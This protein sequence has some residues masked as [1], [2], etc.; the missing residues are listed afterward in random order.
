MKKLLLLISLFFSIHCL[1][2]AQ[3]SRVGNSSC[4]WEAWFDNYCGKTYTAGKNLTIQVKAKNYH[5]IK[6]MELY[7]NG[8]YVGKET[9]YPYDWGKQGK[10]KHLKNM[11]AGTYKMEVKIVDHCGKTKYLKYCE[12]YV[13]GHEPT[14]GCNY[15]NLHWIADI[16]HKYPNHYICEYKYNGHQYFKVYP[17]GQSHYTEYWY[18]CSGHQ[19]CKF[20][21]G[22]PCNTV[23]YAKKV[24][25]WYEPEPPHDTGGGHSCDYHDL[26][27]IQDIKHKYP[28]H[29]ICE[30]RYNGKT[31]Y[32][33]Y[34]CNKSHYTEYWY[35][36]SGH[37]VCKFQNGHACNTVRYAKKVKCWYEPQPPTNNCNYH[38]LDWIE[39][40]KRKY[41]NH[42]ICEYHYNGKTYYQVYPCGKSHY[43]EYWFDCYGHQVCKFQNGR[44][45]STVRNAKKVKCWYDPH[46][47]TPPPTNTG[48]DFDTWFDNPKKQNH[49]WYVKVNVNKH[50]QIKYVDL[51]VNGK[52]A[53][54]ETSYPYDWGKSGKDNYLKNLHRGTYKLHAKIYT[55]C[56]H[57]V[58]KHHEFRV[59]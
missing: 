39:N 26:H 34:P 46:C 24:K 50:H 52:H 54:K 5:R 20:Q 44:P 22:H 2:N 7:I 35:D 55:T 57:V 11:R 4:G 36:C 23:R 19:V 6:Y 56:G 18:D 38:E 42:Y 53:G 9:S 16:K 32:Q 43:T 37:Q 51:Y 27:W 40:I 17:Y 14:G 59:H 45:C 30:Y 1:V 49:R 28:N 47:G 21:N 48:C 31:Y 3:N 10:D 29:Y 25:C 33:V 41:P 12:Y 8:D 58:E 15:H 13:K